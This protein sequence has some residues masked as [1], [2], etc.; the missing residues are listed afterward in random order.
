MT[1]S[2]TAVARAV[3]VEY[4]HSFREARA[5]ACGSLREILS[6]VERG[7]VDDLEV[8]AILGLCNDFLVPY[9]RRRDLKRIAEPATPEQVAEVEGRRG[10]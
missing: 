6:H 3:F 7:E 2:E 10:A 1:E 8:G 5:S 9:R 4:Q